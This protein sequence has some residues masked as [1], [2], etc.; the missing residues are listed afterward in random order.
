[1]RE[2]DGWIG[3]PLTVLPFADRVTMHIVLLRQFRIGEIRALD[4]S[5]SLRGS[6][7]LLDG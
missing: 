6:A 5:P 3:H 7:C 4:L 1:M 2:G